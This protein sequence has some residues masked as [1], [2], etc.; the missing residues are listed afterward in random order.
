MNIVTFF[1]LIGSLL[2]NLA[3]H[4]QSEQYA[5][6]DFAIE[7]AIELTK[8]GDFRAAETQYRNILSVYPDEVTSL[9]NLGSVLQMLLTSLH[10]Y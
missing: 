3:V 2:M 7:N 10:Y 1:V 5:T 6:V 8:R 4:S 9:Q